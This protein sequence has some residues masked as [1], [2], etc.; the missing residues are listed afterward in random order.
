VKAQDKGGTT[1][2]H[3]AS[4]RGHLAVARLLL[5]HDSEHGADANARGQT[6]LH[7]SSRAGHLELVCLLLRRGADVRLWNNEGRSQFQKASAR[8]WDE[9][10]QLLW[11][12]GGHEYAPECD[13][14]LAL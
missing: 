9:V 12:H 14:G 6:P 2:L 7:L 11:E 4:E 3:R 8:G 1:P 10:M 5:E 13:I